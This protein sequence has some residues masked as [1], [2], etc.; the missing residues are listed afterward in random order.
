MS[1]MC[2]RRVLIV[3]FKKWDGVPSV[4]PAVSQIKF[5]SRYANGICGLT[6]PAMFCSC[7]LILW[8]WARSQ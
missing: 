4:V 8:P 1:S 2:L 7:Q 5:F 3:S 6:A